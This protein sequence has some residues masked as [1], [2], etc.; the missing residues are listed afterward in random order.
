MPIKTPID[1]N[2]LI[3]LTAFGLH[4]FRVPPHL[5]LANFSSKV[6]GTMSNE[7]KKDLWIHYN[8]SQISGSITWKS[9][10]WVRTVTSLPVVIKGILT[11]EDAIQAVRVGVKG[12]WISNHGGRQLDTTATAVCN[13]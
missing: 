3:I 7:A 9:I 13:N 5:H 4:R 12:I 10:E 6:S 2:L 8:V 11:A 1:Y